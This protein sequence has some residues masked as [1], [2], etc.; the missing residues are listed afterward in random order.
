MASWDDFKQCMRAQANLDLE[1]IDVAWIQPLKDLQLW[2]DRQ[3][4]QTKA[5][6]NLFTSGLGGSAL[7]AFIVRV[8]GASAAALLSSALES[9]GAVIVGV[10]LGLTLAAMAQCGIQ[11]VDIPAT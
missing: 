4:P 3:G 2:W 10:A 11:T 9:L 5:Y 7:I 8:T 1:A 6:V